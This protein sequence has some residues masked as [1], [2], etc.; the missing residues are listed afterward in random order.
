MRFNQ[1]VV[2]ISAPQLIWDRA[3]DFFSLTKPKLTSLVL[4]TTFVGFYSGIPTAIPLMQL[5]QTLIGT[6]LMAGGAGA[7]NMYLEREL[8]ALMKRT[9]LRPLASGRLKSS[10]A[11]LFALVISAGGFI[12]LFLFV[13][14]LASLLSA[15]IF[16]GYL[17]LYTPMKTKTWWCTLAGA[18]PGAL[19]IVMGWAG[20]RGNLSLEA[21]LLFAI[22]FLWQL[23]HF[24]SI[25]WMYR[26]E[27]AHAGL[28]VLSV[29]DWSGIRTGRQAVLF[30]GVLVVFTLMPARMGLAGSWYLA[31]ALIF[32]AIFLAFGIYFARARNRIAARRLFVVSAFYLPA[33]LILLMLDKPA[34]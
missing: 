6:A 21:W 26:E 27:Y 29:V 4:F 19:P 12:Y 23:P 7:F 10:H 14:H 25:G 15:I 33:L 30:I 5:L 3:T 11:L 28:P 1:G 20:A 8:D 18:V 9:A 32:G 17:F 24:Y 22:V 31:G 2:S 13:N 16:I 34:Y